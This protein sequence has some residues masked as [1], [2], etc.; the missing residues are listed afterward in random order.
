ME[1]EKIY[2]LIEKMYVDLKGDINN[3]NGRFDTLENKVDKNTL[4]L[5]KAQTDIKLIA[6]LQQSFQEQ[7]GMSKDDEG[8]S[9][10]ERLDIIEL[11]VT[12]TSK[13]VKFVKHKLRETEEDVFDIKDHLKLI[14]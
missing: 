4:L 14:K 2:E 7:L 5:E 10:N 9:L 13:D 1:N 8:K 11:A 3:L 12:S 6:E